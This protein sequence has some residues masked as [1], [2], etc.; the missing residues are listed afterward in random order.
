MR[1]SVAVLLCALAFA[2]GGDKNPGDDDGHGDDDQHTDSDPGTIA[3]AL[4]RAALTLPEAS[5][6]DIVLT[7][8]LTGDLTGSAVVYTVSAPPTGVTAAIAGNTLTLTAALLASNTVSTITVSASAGGQTTTAD[9]A[10]TVVPPTPF[11]VNGRVLAWSKGRPLASGMVD[12]VTVR[13]WKRGATSPQ[14]VSLL[15][16]D[17]FTF[18]DVVPPYDLVYEVGVGVDVPRV[19]RQLMIGLTRADPTIVYLGPVPEPSSPERNLTVSFGAPNGLRWGMIS[20]GCDSGPWGWGW[21]FHAGPGSMGNGLNGLAVDAETTCTGDRFAFELDSNEYLPTTYSALFS[22]SVSANLTESGSV[23][24]DIPV[25]TMAETPRSLAVDATFVGEVTD[26]YFEVVWLPGGVVAQTLNAAELTGPLTSIAAPADSDIQL[27]LC[28]S[29]AKINGILP[30]V[31]GVGTTKCRRL[32]SDRTSVV[33]G[34]IA[35]AADPGAPTGTVAA[36][37]VAFTP[38]AAFSG[39]VI[40]GTSFNHLVF[41]SG[42]V[43]A[44]LLTARGMALDI[45]DG[46]EWQSMSF[47][48]VSDADA[49]ATPQVTRGGMATRDAGYT[50]SGTAT[51]ETN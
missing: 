42:V 1:R 37:Q 3:L 28:L 39:Y 14:S 47:E 50:F 26:G 21:W 25:G 41:S 35:D 23:A 2:C 5:S 11:T 4:D 29:T 48:G 20:V 34:D 10:V 31:D 32:A 51:F 15:D 36:S 16:S 43:D 13:L 8:T 7:T 27:A 24:F 46:Y 22:S 18:S 12:Q 6:A 9:L 30:D 33:F 40:S 44:A 38:S 49:F 45:G 17:S 19:T